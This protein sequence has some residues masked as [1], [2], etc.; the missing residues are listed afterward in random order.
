M[1]YMNEKMWLL[2]L[3]WIK[4]LLEVT[5]FLMKYPPLPPP[6]TKKTKK[7]KK[8]IDLVTYPVNESWNV[9]LA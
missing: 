2:E 4:I 8:E 1:K 7:K 6:Q 3:G 9:V 5:G